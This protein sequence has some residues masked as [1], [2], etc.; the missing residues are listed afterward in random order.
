MLDLSSDCT[1]RLMILCQLGTQ[2]RQ[3]KLQTY[4]SVELLSPS[5]LVIGK[6]EDVEISSALVVHVYGPVLA[7]AC[8]IML[9]L[10]V[11]IIDG[12]AGIFS[13]RVLRPSGIK[14]L[15]QAHVHV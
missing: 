3:L 4:L 10:E 14:D 2:Y 12:T 9:P 1:A 15:L 11:C 6:G 5:R 8:G 7:F 13:M